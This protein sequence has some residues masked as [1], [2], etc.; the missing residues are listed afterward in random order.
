MDVPAE[1]AGYGRRRTAALRHNEVAVRDDEFAGL[2]ER[3]ARFMFRVAYSL[4]RNVQDAEDAVQEAFLKL[5]RGEAWRR[6]E[7]ERAFL[8]RTV[9]RMALDRAPRGMDRM[10]DVTEIEIADGGES[11]EDWA[12]GGDE[13]ALL[14][15]MIAGLPEELRQ[16]LLL[17]SVEEMTSGEVAS[18]MGIPEGTVR[19]RVMRAKAELRKRFAAMGEVRR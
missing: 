10:A 1:W 11:P 13:R 14:R 2:V 3:Q 4:L 8:A 9:W 6:M 18:V 5:Y 15:Q 19:T 12:G 16:A 7:N 17:S